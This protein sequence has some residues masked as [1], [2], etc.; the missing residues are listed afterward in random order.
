MIKN[1]LTGLLLTISFGLLAQNQEKVLVEASNKNITYIGRFDFSDL[2]KPVFMYSGCAIRT[3]F[4]G[5]SIDMVM[6]DDSLRNWFTVIL[7]DSLFVIKTNKKDKRYSL[8][9]NLE[10]KMHS[11][12]II[13]RTEWHGGNSTFEG[14]YIDKKSK[15]SKPELKK[16]QIEF[17]GD[18]YTCGYG[19]EGASHDE[20]FKYETE[21]AYQTYCAI[22]SRALN[23][24]CIT[25]CRSGIGMYK[26]YDGDEGFNMPT[27]YDTIAAGKSYTWNYKKS[28][29]QLVVV[30]LGGNDANT[31]I[32]SLKFSNSYLGFLA[33]IRHNYPAAKIL[34][35]SDDP[36]GD[37]KVILL[38]Y[39]IEE[40]VKTFSK[41]NKSVYYCYLGPIQTDGSDWHPNITGHNQIAEKLI[42]E[43][44]RIMKW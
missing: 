36:K 40:V 17:I 5:T 13:R 2:Q 8:A 19:N 43:I 1:Y 3:V 25:V 21:N 32:D 15:L 35:L 23:A 11:I 24:E 27:L 10:N 14:F 44:K 31:G 12:E 33:R 9:N 16:R 38:N 29:P 28:Q 42:P 30:Y 18:S 7:D 26:G 20:H 4:T 34:C 37:K 39:C 6:Q 41:T 22:A